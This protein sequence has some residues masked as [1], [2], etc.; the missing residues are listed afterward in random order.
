MFCSA[1]LQELLPLQLQLRSSVV[2]DV[3]GECAGHNVIYASKLSLL[4]QHTMY[5]ICT[6]YLYFYTL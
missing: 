5:I 6:L 1:N 2:T 4:V 3:N